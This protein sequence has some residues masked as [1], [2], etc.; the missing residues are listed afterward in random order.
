MASELTDLYLTGEFDKVYL[1]YT[2]FHSALN[3]EVRFEEFLP[4]KT[5]ASAEEADYL[6]EPDVKTIVD[7]FIPH[8]ILTKI[9]SPSSSRRHRK[10]RPAWRRWKT[11]RTTAA[12]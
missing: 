8:Y 2:Y 11:Q 10:T 9:F 4:L 6:Y 12:R 3:Q 1:I 5:E 7:R